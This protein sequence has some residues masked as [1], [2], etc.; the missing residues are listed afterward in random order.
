MIWVGD[1]IMLCRRKN[2]DTWRG[3][4]ANAG[5]SVEPTDE[6]LSHA[7]QRELME[8]TGY[9]LNRAEIEIIDCYQ[10]KNFKCFIFEG[11]IPSYRFQDIKNTEP[12]KHT[13]WELFTIEEALK[14]KLMPSIREHLTN[15]L[16]TLAKKHAS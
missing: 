4:W 8:E 2:T 12:D 13:E 7:V 11:Q 5:G 9:Y 3:Y 1:K 14:L 6:S 10:E 16:D 15:N